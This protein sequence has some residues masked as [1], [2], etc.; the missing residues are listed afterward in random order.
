[1]YLSDLGRRVLQQPLAAGQSNLKITTTQYKAYTIEELLQ[2][3]FFMYHSGY[4]QGQTK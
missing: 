1:M 4:I 2:Q 3:N